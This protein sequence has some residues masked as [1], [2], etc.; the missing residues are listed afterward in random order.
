MNILNIKECDTITL[1]PEWMDKGDETI[2]FE[3]VEDHNGGR[4][5]YIRNRDGSMFI[6]PTHVVENYMIES[7]EKQAG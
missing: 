6:N 5:I 7:F 1:K 2:T 4:N 3:A